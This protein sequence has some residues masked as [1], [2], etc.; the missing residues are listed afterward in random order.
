[1]FCRCHGI[2]HVRMPVACR[3]SLNKISSEELGLE[4]KERWEGHWLAWAGG[5]NLQPPAPEFSYGL[6]DLKQSINQSI[7]SS[8]SWLLC[9][10]DTTSSSAGVGACT[11]LMLVWFKCVQVQP[12]HHKLYCSTVMMWCIDDVMFRPSKKNQM[13]WA[14]WL[15]QSGGFYETH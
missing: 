11:W 3:N 13:K 5:L 8:S 12:C 7:P 15:F 2:F 6:L 1:M 9:R 14:P 4:T 10:A